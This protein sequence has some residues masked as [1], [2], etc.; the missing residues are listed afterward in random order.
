MNIL[1]LFDGMSCGRIALERAGIPITNYFASE[2]DKN[3]LKV[4]QANYPD[5][6]RLGDVNDINLDALP[7]IDILMGGSPCQGFSVAGKQ[8]N[9]EDPRSKLFF[10]FVEI[11]KA[12]KP[13][14]FLLEN[15]KMKKEWEDIISEHMGVSPIKINSSLVSAQNR[16]RLYWTN[17]P[18]V[19]QPEDKELLLAD[20]VGAYTSIYVEPRGTNPGGLSWYKGKSPSITT[21][22]WHH[23][24]FIVESDAGF[25]CVDREKSYCID[26]NY[27]KGGNPK[28][29][30][31]K[32]RRQ[33]VFKYNRKVGIQFDKEELDKALTLLES[34]WRGLNR[35]Q[36]QNCVVDLHNLTYRKFTPEECELL[37]TV[38]LG[39]TACVANTQR[40][41]MLGNG[42][43]VD[44]IA[45]IL[46]YINEHSS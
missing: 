2:I 17:I 21:S 24:F 33:L 10:K 11:M 45:H 13:K 25:E 37:Q 20:I 19:Q 7:P 30:F 22:S 27:W 12:V 28:S 41:K 6:I 40:Y 4:S 43:T 34:D 18:N 3:C 29:Y 8:L 38:P 15:V 1:S 36:N 26:A 14:Y 16:V 44:V 46:G 9:F 32:G 35:N 39:Y 31:G 42:W 5:I 23:N